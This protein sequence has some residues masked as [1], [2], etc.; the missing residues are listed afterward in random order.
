MSQSVCIL[1]AT[2]SIGESTLKVLQQH[3]DKYSVFAV[4][5]YSRLEKLVEIC[6]QFHPQVA[7]VPSTQQDRLAQL[8]KQHQIDYTEILTDEAGLVAVAEHP[9]VDIVMAAIVGAAGLLPTLAAVKASKRVLLANKEALVMSGEIMM[10]A[11]E[12]HQALLLPVDSEHNAI[13]QCLPNGYC[14]SERT[15]QPKQ[16]VSRILLTASGGPFL[17]TSLNDLHDVTP[18]QACKHPNWSMGQ[19][20]SVDSATL[21]NKGLEL[22]EAC[23][24]FSIS[25]HFVTVVIHPQSIIHSMVQYVDGST[26]AQMGN[27]DMCTP[28]AHALAWPQRIST[29]VDALDLFVHQQLNFQQPDTIKFPALRLARHA[30]QAGGVAPAILNAANEIAVAAF[31]QQKIKFTAIPEVVE[32]TLNDMENAQA[33]SLETIL[34]ADQFARNIA[35]QRVD[36]L[37]LK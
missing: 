4:T 8:F 29:P 1:G 37:R 19:K 24:L 28:I 2:G 20:I 25:E 3:P 15:G 17:N 35:T 14:Q 5:A 6:K 36:A 32:H 11:A 31:L 18:A 9:Q 22:I 23:H 16:G 7:V 13:F 30:M 33:N 34:Q 27:P 21:M 12:Q 10:Q 26:L